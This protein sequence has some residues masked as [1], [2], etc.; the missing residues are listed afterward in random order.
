MNEMTGG[1]VTK[2]KRKKGRS[3]VYEIHVNGQF[4]C[5]VSED[6]LVRERILPGRAVNEEELQQWIRH[7]EQFEAMDR[8]LR[9]LGR[10][11]YAKKEIHQRLIQAA[12]SPET[13]EQVIEELEAKGYL[14]EWEFAIQHVQRR[15]KTQ[16]KGR[17]W[18]ISELLEK[19]ISREMIDEALQ[20]IVPEEEYEAAKS[21][22]LKK[23]KQSDKLELQKRK[24]RVAQSLMRRGVPSEMVWKIVAEL[25]EQFENESDSTE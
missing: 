6:L 2:V 24:Q 19:G 3:P 25:E 17:M 7:G 15:M 4:H 16:K 8:A 14:N 20:L 23:W 22:G 1:T 5:F 21:Y 13:A 12:Y 9:W 11:L 18:V 10:R